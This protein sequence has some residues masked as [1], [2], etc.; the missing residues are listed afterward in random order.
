[1]L[2]LILMGAFA[3]MMSSCVAPA[4]TPTGPVI[5]VVEGT[6]PPISTRLSKVNPIAPTATPQGANGLVT[7]TP[8]VTP[9]T[10]AQSPTTPA[11][12]TTPTSG[13]STNTTETLAPA[14]RTPL[15]T[16]NLTLPPQSQPN[17]SIPSDTPTA[18][19]TAT[20]TGVPTPSVTDGWRLLNYNIVENSFGDIHLLG[21]LEN[22]TGNTYYA[23]NLAVT[24]KDASGQTVAEGFG[25]PD[26]AFMPPA[27]RAP[28][29]VIATY[30][31]IDITEYQTLELAVDPG[32][33]I[34]D[35][36]RADLAV[37]NVQLTSQTDPGTNATYYVV[38]GNIS[39]LGETPYDSVQIS[40]ALLD[41]SGKTSGIGL[42]YP[43][44]DGSFT[45][46]IDDFFG[47]PVS[48]HIAAIG[49]PIP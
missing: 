42:A 11:S 7:P 25:V 29:H 40:V 6:A 2:F 41:G 49:V 47:T 16:A 5:Q 12:A 48:Y 8:I 45:L 9:S 39:N 14:T 13:G 34:S 19:P 44:P 10:G 30:I 38:T 26:L 4:T 24:F 15:P 17:P 37:S 31:D 18:T 43:E 27:L 46:E 23:P 28:F 1:M 22:A 3:A 21:I 35:P 33:P 32:D 36:V 20:P